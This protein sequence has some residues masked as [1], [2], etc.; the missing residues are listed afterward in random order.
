MT[1]TSIQVNLPPPPPP[2]SVS[3]EARDF[4]RLA[5]ADWAHTDISVGSAALAQLRADNHDAGFNIGFV[6]FVKR[7]CAI[8]VTDD[9]VFTNEADS[10]HTVKAQWVLPKRSDPAASDTVV[11]YFFGGGSVVG[12]PEDDLCMSARLAH[13]TGLALCAPRYRLAP[14]SPFPAARDDCAVVF[15]ALAARYARVVVAGESMGAHLA[16]GLVLD[17]AKTPDAKKIPCVVLWSP[18]ID[19][20]HSGDSHITNNGGDPTLSVPH[21]LHPAAVAYA[22]GRPLASPEI[23]PLFRPQGDFDGFPPCYISSATRDLLLSDCA[24]LAQK[25]QLTDNANEVTLAIAEGLWHV[26]EWTPRL[27][28]ARRS[29]EA[30]SRFIKRHLK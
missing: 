13:L 5:T 1:S 29:M 4:I 19:L 23:S 27:P 6:K 21:F 24:L 28:E 22:G 2:S 3:A 15:R 11:L 8:E 14:E 20:S 16:L 25:L 26:Y 12:S 7:E 18:W 9:E 30:V 17:V 10:S